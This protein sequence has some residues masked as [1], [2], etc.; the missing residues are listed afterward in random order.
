M[1][2]L[3]SPSWLY[4]RTFCAKLGVVTWLHGAIACLVL[5]AGCAGRQAAQSAAVSKPPAPE[6]RPK[7]VLKHGNAWGNYIVVR[8]FVGR[9]NYV[10]AVSWHGYGTLGKESRFE[11]AGSAVDDAFTKLGE[12]KSNNC[13]SPWRETGAW[14]ATLQVS[15]HWELIDFT[16]SP[17]KSDDRC[18]KLVRAA[19]NLFELAITRW[20]VLPSD[21]VTSSASP[22]THF[23]VQ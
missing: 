16:D 12:G 8:Y 2:V 21:T 18:T 10:S 22:C 4:H 14:I 15:G 1:C 11:I 13:R 6:E 9:E 5:L 7:Y 19:S 23:A 20:P 3:A 17:S